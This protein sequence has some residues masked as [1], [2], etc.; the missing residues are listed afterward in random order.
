M[1]GG[2]GATSEAVP[3]MACGRLLRGEESKRLRI[4]PRCLRRLQGL[5]APRPRRRL[6]YAPVHPK[7]M[8]PPTA[9][10]ALELWDDDEDEDEFDDRV[11]STL[12]NDVPLTGSYL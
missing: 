12:I 10:V 5:L 3:C 1:T 7:A 2:D 4:G 11:G 9:P 8:P 6:R